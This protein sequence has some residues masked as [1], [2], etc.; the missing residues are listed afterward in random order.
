M[1]SYKKVLLFP[2]KNHAAVAVAGHVEKHGKESAIV[3]SSLGAT[4]PLNA[5]SDRATAEQKYCGQE[6]PNMKVFPAEQEKGTR[7]MIDLLLH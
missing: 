6:K 4:L 1:I 2:P 5:S 3:V 7:T